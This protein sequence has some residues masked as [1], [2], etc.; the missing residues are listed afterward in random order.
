MSTNLSDYELPP[1]D[2]PEYWKC[3]LD[4]QGRL[5]Y[6]HVKIRIPQWE[7]PIKLLPLHQQLE[8]PVLKTDTVDSDHDDDSHKQTSSAMK[9]NLAESDSD[10]DAESGNST[11]DTEDSSEDE[12]QNKLTLIRKNIKSKQSDLGK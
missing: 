7:P 11:T 6:Y 10:E 9:Q 12:L 4:N 8:S 2:L 1:L 5:Y 3:A